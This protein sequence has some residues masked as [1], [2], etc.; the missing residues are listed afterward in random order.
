MAGR[1]VEQIE[2]HDVAHGFHPQKPLPPAVTEATRELW[3]A[4]PQLGRIDGGG[5]TGGQGQ[6]DG[7]CAAVADVVLTG[8]ENPHISLEIQIDDA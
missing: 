2:Q 6:L 1:A 8:N 7:A 4:C 3:T 5:T